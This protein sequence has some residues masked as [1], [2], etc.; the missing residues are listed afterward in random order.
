MSAPYGL[1][2]FDLDG[3]LIDTV[4]DIA[5]YVN[6][7]LSEKGYAPASVTQVKEA[8]GW[9]VSDLLKILVPS[10]R[11]DPRSLENAVMTFKNHYREEP[12]RTTRPFP[13]VIEALEGPLRKTHKAIITNKPQD[14]ALRVLD[15]LNMRHYFEDVIGM[16]GAF[17]PKPDPASSLHLMRKFSIPVEA[18]VYIGDSPVDAE[19]SLAAGIDFVW[20]EY[21][22][23]PFGASAPRFR[24]SSA[25]DWRTLV[26]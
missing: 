6:E 9:G 4:D 2:L 23:Q 26:S 7:V 1:I 17:P 20:M 14:I 19:T 11:D 22:Y 21:G 5:Y 16:Q 24:F 13:E 3:T 12:V 18:T 8:I 15:K 10:F 25:A